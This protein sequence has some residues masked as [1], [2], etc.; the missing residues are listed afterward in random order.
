MNF[1]PGRAAGEV[2]VGLG[3]G[4]QRAEIDGIGRLPLAFRW[5]VGIVR[6]TG[7]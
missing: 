3:K 6:T 5:V 4:D 1:P 7:S 2:A